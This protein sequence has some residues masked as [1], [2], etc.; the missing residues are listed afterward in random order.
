MNNINTYLRSKTHHIKD[1]NDFLQV[2]NFIK[3]EILC[4]HSTDITMDELLQYANLQNND[5][6]FEFLIPKKRKGL[7]RQICAPTDR[8]KEI[9]RAVN[10]LLSYNFSSKL[11]VTGFTKK[12]SV[13]VNASIHIQ[14]PFVFNIDLYDFFGSITLSNIVKRLRRFPYYFSP[15]V[16]S[17][18]ARLS[19][20]STKG[21]SVVSLAQ[22]SPASPIISNLV[23][24]ELDAQLYD[25]SARYGI[26]YS[27][28]ADDITFSGSENIFQFQKPFYLKLDQIISSH[29]FRINL[30]KVRLLPSSYRQVVT[31]LIVNEKVNVTKAYIKEI[32]NLLY[33]WEKYGYGNAYRRFYIKNDRRNGITNFVNFLRGKLNYLC[34]VKGEN[35]SVYL[36]FKQKFDRLNRSSKDNFKKSYGSLHDFEKKYGPI[37]IDINSLTKERGAYIFRNAKFKIECVISSKLNDIV[38]NYSSEINYIIHEFCTVCVI[39]DK[40]RVKYLIAKKADADLSKYR[41]PVKNNLS[42]LT[43]HIPPVD[44]NMPSI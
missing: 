5:R 32:R 41:I 13:V 27:R 33:I 12:T 4:F 3:R 11:Y 2:I 35:D 24:E 1:V 25:L 37:N 9:L 42:S 44:K 43:K 36:R 38:E 31:G 29:H 23:C 39:F 8:L 7:Y 16:S 40:D 18:I 19:C 28:Y 17:V 26:R 6:Y 15:E 21:N 30:N 22:G 20:V 14:Q 10:Y 34:C